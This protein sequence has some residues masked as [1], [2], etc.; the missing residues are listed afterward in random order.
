MNEWV[1]E[2]MEEEND[3]EKKKVKKE[4]GKCVWG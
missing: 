1:K 2:V 3:K 4:G